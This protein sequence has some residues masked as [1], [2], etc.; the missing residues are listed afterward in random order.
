MLTINEIAW[1]L[2]NLLFFSSQPPQLQAFL[3]NTFLCMLNFALSGFTAETGVFDFIH[4]NI[5][6]IEIVVETPMREH[7]IVI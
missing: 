6:N 3:Q 4:S 1:F 2:L 7:I 5:H